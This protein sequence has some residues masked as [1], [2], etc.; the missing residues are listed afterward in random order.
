[1]IGIRR[2]FYFLLHLKNIQNYANS[3]CYYYSCQFGK[4]VSK[5]QPVTSRKN[6]K[7]TIPKY[8]HCPVQIHVTEKEGIVNA[9]NFSN[10]FH[11]LTFENWKHHYLKQSARNLIKAYLRL[12]VLIAK[13]KKILQADF[14]MRD[15]D[16][17]P[18]KEAFI[19]N[20]DISAYKRYMFKALHPF[21]H[22]L[23]LYII[24]SLI[25][26]YFINT[27]VHQY[28]MVLQILLHCQ[29]AINSLLWVSMHYNKNNAW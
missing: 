18:W 7:G 11:P 23:I 8:V 6:N 27:N 28:Y 14:G 24:E 9:M 3:N 1:M 21:H 2:Y 25:W 4:H 20:K 10:H 15:R 12:S 17:F 19:L 29:M 26:F 13:I 5:F 16:F 22:W